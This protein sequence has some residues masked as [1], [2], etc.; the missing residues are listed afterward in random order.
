[1]NGARAWRA[2]AAQGGAYLYGARKTRISISRAEQIDRTD[3]CHRQNRRRRSQQAAAGVPLLPKRGSVTC[4]QRS[5]RIRRPIRTPSEAAQAR[6]PT[7]MNDPKRKPD[8]PEVDPVVPDDEDAGSATAMFRRPPG[9]A[10]AEASE[11]AEFESA[12]PTHDL[13][14]TQPQAAEDPAPSK[15][16]TPAGEFTR[17]FEAFTPGESAPTYAKASEPTVNPTPN[18]ESVSQEPGDFT[19][20]FLQVPAP[21][22][23]TPRSIEKTAEP[24]STAPSQ[25]P[26]AG[27]MGPGEFT[28]FL[29]GME[30]VPPESSTVRPESDLPAARKLKGFSTPG[31][32]GFASAGPSGITESF[33]AAPS[34]PETPPTARFEDDRVVSRPFRRPPDTA[35]QRIPFSPRPEE[36][37]GPRPGEAGEFTR[38]MKSLSDTASR[39]MQEGSGPL[40]GAAAGA[41]SSQEF[42]AGPGEFTRLMKGL[43]GGTPP[44]EAALPGFERADPPPL[45]KPV[46]QEAGD[47]TRIISGSLLRQAQPAEPQPV[48]VTNAAAAGPLSGLP[49]VPHPLMP[50]APQ[51]PQVPHVPTPPA[52]PVAP[53]KGKLERSLPLLLILNAFLLAVLILLVAFSLRGR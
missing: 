20:I 50:A 48:P 37:T 16:A 47:Y 25:P 14:S 1:M 24:A 8:R 4:P 28:R 33:S 21:A 3:V 18:T 42:Q 40:T 41:T 44:E 27:E 30:R 52:L 39:P 15:P 19:R 17:F 5:A 2:S 23:E 35:E 22:V 36:R 38:L 34:A 32:A 45:P 13:L 31:A 46:P 43:S 51:V 11:R 53:P 49:P 26:Q 12:R 29:S 10:P 6:I 9:V 7:L